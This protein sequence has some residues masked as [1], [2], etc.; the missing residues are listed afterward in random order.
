MR[1]CYLS[2]C[3]LFFDV[4]T[5]SPCLHI[6]SVN[7][8]LFFNC[9]NQ[10]DIKYAVVLF[11]FYEKHVIV[12]KYVFFIHRTLVGSGV[13]YFVFKQSLCSCGC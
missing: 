12:L 6:F 4:S 8:N 13:E 11:F 2:V 10:I 9:S 7:T 3:L 1:L 5:T